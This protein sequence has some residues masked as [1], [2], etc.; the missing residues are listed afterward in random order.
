[1]WSTSAQAGARSETRPNIDSMVVM[2]SVARYKQSTFFWN[3][4]YST[5]LFDFDQRLIRRVAITRSCNPSIF[6]IHGHC[7]CRLHLKCDIKPYS[8]V[9]NLFDKYIAPLRTLCVQIESA[10]VSL[11]VRYKLSQPTNNNIIVILCTIWPFAIIFTSYCP[12][13]FVCI[14]FA[15]CQRTR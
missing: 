10:H 1:M 2:R 7:I 13:I 14:P 3:F 15:I 4:T 12:S 5:L 8:L 11:F 9:L 6:P